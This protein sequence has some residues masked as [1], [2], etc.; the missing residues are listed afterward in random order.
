M[1]A[2]GKLTLRTGPNL[3]HG[4]EPMPEADGVHSTAPLNTSAIGGN[5]RRL[6]SRSVEPVPLVVVLTICGG[7]LLLH[8][9]LWT[10][11]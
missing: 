1:Q 6:M 2:G 7:S 3:K 5:F 11:P 9:A 4:M 8:I 10:T